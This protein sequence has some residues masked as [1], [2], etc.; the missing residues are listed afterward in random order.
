MPAH[1]SAHRVHRELGHD[2]VFAVRGSTLAC[3]STL[4]PREGAPQEDDSLGTDESMPPMTCSARGHWQPRRR[5]L[6]PHI[7]EAGALLTHRDAHGTHWWSDGSGIFKGSPPAYLRRACLAAGMMVDVTVKSVPL[8]LALARYVPGTRLDLPIASYPASGAI[9]TIPVDV[10]A[11]DAEGPELHVD[12][13]YVAFARAQFTG[14]T[15]WRVTDDILGVR[16]HAQDLVGIIQRRF[17][18]PQP[19]PSRK[20]KGFAT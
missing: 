12:A 14:C 20:R 9:G 16:D 8:I 13:R 10:F 7:G 19:K 3:R 18:P 11:A 5:R 6:D 1:G 15:F 17:P 4:R 2:P